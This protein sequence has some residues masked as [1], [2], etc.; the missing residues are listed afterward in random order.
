MKQLIYNG[1]CRNV[2]D[3]GLPAQCVTADVPD[4]LGLAYDNHVDKMPLGAYLNFLS[5]VVTGA[6]SISDVFWL[7]Y[8]YKYAPA[9]YD[10]SKFMQRD[11]RHMYWVFNFGQH[12]DT[13]FS[14]DYR[15]IARFSKENWVPDMDA[16]R[17]E[18]ERQ[19]IGDIRANPEGRCPSDIWQFPRV[20]GNSAERR[21]YHPTQINEKVMERIYKCSRCSW[22]IDLCG[23]TGTSLRVAER[24]GIGMLV[25][26]TSNFYCGKM[27]LQLR[28]ESAE[29]TTNLQD[30][31]SWMK[32]MNDGT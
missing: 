22:A 28:A 23:G 7:L 2:L 8:Y 3:L 24:L 26:E 32:G 31:R 6:C 14:N 30:V 4:N 13:D 10:M 21:T 18:S 5:E 17:I 27:L 29:I 15:P 1:D 20:T 25:C 16:V 19:R 12:R 11:L 9:V